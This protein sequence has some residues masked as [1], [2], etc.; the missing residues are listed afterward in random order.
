M[1]SSVLQPWDGS[2]KMWKLQVKHSSEKRAARALKH[3][4]VIYES[5]SLAESSLA[6]KILQVS[7]KWS[8]MSRD[9]SKQNVKGEKVK[10][11]QDRVTIKLVQM[12]L[13]GWWYTY[14]SKKY[15]FV[16]WDDY[17]QYV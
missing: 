14:P 3:S 7:P 16:S 17:S 12:N 11:Q 9:A 5:S 6:S 15:E 1:E 8:A 13:S 2:L 4:V 10:S